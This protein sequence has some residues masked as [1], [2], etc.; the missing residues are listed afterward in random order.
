M[1]PGKGPSRGTSKD[2]REMSSLCSRMGGG[3]VGGVWYPDHPMEQSVAQ[4]RPRGACPSMWGWR[5]GHG[6][7]SVKMFFQPTALRV[8]GGGRMQMDPPK[9][10]AMKFHSMKVNWASQLEVSSHGTP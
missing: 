8:I 9:R 6:G 2:Q 10:F 1:M 3:E 5:G 7:Q 4:A